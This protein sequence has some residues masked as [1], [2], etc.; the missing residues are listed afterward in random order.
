VRVHGQTDVLPFLPW[1][2]HAVDCTRAGRNATRCAVLL[3]KQRAVLSRRAT[4]LLQTRAAQ[5]PDSEARTRTGT[6]T[7]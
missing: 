1:S 3:A 6:S 7:G 2:V 4:L 5:S